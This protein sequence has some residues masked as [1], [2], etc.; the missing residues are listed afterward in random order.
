MCLCASHQPAPGRA[1]A[2]QLAC[3]TSSI[4]LTCQPTV[5]GL[6]PSGEVAGRGRETAGLYML[7]WQ[8]SRLACNGLELRKRHQRGDHRTPPTL[9]A[10]QL[11]QPGSMRDK[12]PAVRALAL[13]QTDASSAVK[14]DAASNCSFARGP[15]SASQTVTGAVHSWH[16]QTPGA[17]RWPCKRCAAMQSTGNAACTL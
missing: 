7:L 1:P 5:C 14:G 8:S 2:G 13:Q 6:V 10:Q 9:R 3:C 16:T 4:L 15:G 17:A 12:L 11:Q